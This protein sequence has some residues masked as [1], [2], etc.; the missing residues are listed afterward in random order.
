MKINNYFKSELEFKLK[1]TEIKACAESNS[2]LVF[3]L[4]DLAVTRT[5]RRLLD[6]QDKA[7]LSQRDVLGPFSTGDIPKVQVDNSDSLEILLMWFFEE[8]G[9]LIRS[10]S[11]KFPIEKTSLKVSFEVK[12]YGEDQ[13]NTQILETDNIFEAEEK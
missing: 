3:R 1:D 13:R 5:K 11:Q 12:N 2:S 9:E 7:V 8:M 4:I 10:N 6:L